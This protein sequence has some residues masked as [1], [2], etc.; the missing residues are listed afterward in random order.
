[1]SR[2][3]NDEL[4][5]RKPQEFSHCKNLISTTN[6]SRASCR[7][8]WNVPT[9]VV[10]ASCIPVSTTRLRQIF[11]AASQRANC[12]HVYQPSTP[13]SPT[14]N[15]TRSTTEVSEQPF[16]DLL[17]KIT[18]NFVITYIDIFVV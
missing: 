17:L 10:T 18:Q 13:Q 11:L 2:I 8:S 4:A 15:T 14:V 6:P 9:G 5:G 7:P 12:L 1:M 3:S 16:I